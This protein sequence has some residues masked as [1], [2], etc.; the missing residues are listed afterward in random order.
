MVSN[1]RP[2]WNEGRD[3][4]YHGV[5]VGVG[6]GGLNVAGRGNSNCESN[7][8]EGSRSVVWQQQGGRCGLSGVTVHGPV[9][10]GAA[11]GLSS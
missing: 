2:E 7:L 8:R 11:L 10:S 4:R 9:P 3:D 5:G 6:G 1:H